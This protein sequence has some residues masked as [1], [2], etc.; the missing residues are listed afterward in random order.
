MSIF[1]LYGPFNCISFHK[2]SRRLFAFSLCSS[3]VISALLVL[4]TTYFFMKV[5]FSPDI[6]LSWLTGLKAPTNLLVIIS[7]RPKVWWFVQLCFDALLNRYC[8]MCADSTYQTMFRYED[9][10]LKVE[11]IDCASDSVR[12]HSFLC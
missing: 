7:R 5:S 11:I 12:N 9:A 3:G 8:S 6:I 4:S 10:A 1:C 2:F